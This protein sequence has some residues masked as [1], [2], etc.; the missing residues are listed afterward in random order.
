SCIDDPLHDEAGS[1]AYLWCVVQS[2]PSGMATLPSIPN[3][4]DICQPGDPLPITIIYFD[5]TA[6]VAAANMYAMK[7]N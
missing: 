3:S 5:K 2:F 4:P 1:V 6:G 7:I